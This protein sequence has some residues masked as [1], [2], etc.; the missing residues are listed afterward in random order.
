MDFV[1][2]GENVARS[3]SSLAYS[4]RPVVSFQFTQC[5]SFYSLVICTGEI[6]SGR[7]RSS[8][9]RR[10]KRRCFHKVLFFAHSK[11]ESNIALFTSLAYLVSKS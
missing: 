1:A 9:S 3:L 2:L 6:Y 11:L 10:R 5:I 8:R 7:S 4:A